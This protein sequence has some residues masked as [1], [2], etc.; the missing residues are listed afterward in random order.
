MTLSKGR[1]LALAIILPVGLA[2]AGCGVTG[3]GNMMAAGAQPSLYERLGGQ[4]SIAA[5][6]DDFIANVAA[7]ERI[8]QRFA[9]AD[10]T[11]LKASLVDQ[12]CEASGGPC[13][14]AGPDM[15]TAHAGMNISE[16]EFDAL[17]EDLVKSLEKLKVPAVEQNEL[18][19]ALGGMKGD[20]VGV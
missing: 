7:D 17:V 9:G 15:R 10:I 2:V 14:Y 1:R 4:P 20:I 18:L 5:V 16:A 8:N 11:R 3:D 6:V 19:S 12:I 13:A